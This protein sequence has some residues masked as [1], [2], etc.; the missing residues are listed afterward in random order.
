MYVCDIATVTV[1]AYLFNS[2]RR[3][4]RPDKCDD[5]YWPHAIDILTDIE[6]F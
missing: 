3:S 5:T 2:I 1:N 6:I 4:K